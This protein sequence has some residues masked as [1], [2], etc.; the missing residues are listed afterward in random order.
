MLSYIRSVLL[1]W[2]LI[3]LFCPA[4]GLAQAVYVSAG[5]VFTIS[6]LETGLNML[7]PKHRVVVPGFYM[8]AGIGFEVANNAYVQAGLRRVQCR[9][10]IPFEIDG[11]SSIRY[12]QAFW[13]LPL[14]VWMDFPLRNDWYWTV[15][16]GLYV[17][18]QSDAVVAGVPEDHAQFTGGKAEFGMEAGSGIVYRVDL[19]SFA[20]T[21]RATTLVN[22]SADLVL[23]SDANKLSS[24][25]AVSKAVFPA[26]MVSY[27]RDLK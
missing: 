12:Q 18:L 5:S 15:N 2:L 14:S 4:V 23:K 25:N 27:R 26:V 24:V 7:L 22:P 17:A 16:G 10:Q 9:Q 19:N 6:R 3:A 11:R 8:E 13:H 20:L 1:R 21:G